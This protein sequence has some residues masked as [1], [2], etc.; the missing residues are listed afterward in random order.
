VAGPL[1]DPAVHDHVVGGAEPGLAT[2]DGLQFLARPERGVLGGR[3]G[4][5]DVLGAG[6]VTAAERALLGVVR[7]VQQLTAVFTRRADVDHGLAEV[8]QHVVAE[9]PDLGVVPLDHRVVGARPVRRL[10]AQRAALRDPL[11]P[12]AVQQADVRVA[13]QRGDPQGVRRPPVVPV[14]VDHERGIPADAFLRHQPREPGPV[15]VI[16]GDRVVQLGVPVQL[17]RA[18]DVPRLVQQHVLVGLGDHQPGVAEVLGHPAGAD[19]HLGPG[20]VLE[21]GRGVIRQRHDYPH[22]RRWSARGR[23]RRWR[24]MSPTGQQRPGAAGPSPLAGW[25]SRTPGWRSRTPGRT[26]RPQ[27]S[28]ARPTPGWPRRCRSPRRRSARARPGSAHPAGH[29]TR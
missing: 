28:A 20:V 3:A 8:G 18:R 10:G 19:Q 6:D 22:L 13:E 14:A 25:R 5:G 24:R 21:L 4:P 7:H 17:D 27:V 11:G 15:H 9:R 29:R 23:A 26:G 16:P 2:V 1:A 12:A